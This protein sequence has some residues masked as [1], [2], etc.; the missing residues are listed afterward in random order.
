[1][2]K[3]ETKKSKSGSPGKKIKAKPVKSK[4][5][6]V[7]KKIVKKKAKPKKKVISDKELIVVLAYIKNRT[8]S[9]ARCYRLGFPDCERMSAYP[10]AT[11]LFQRPHV[12]KYIDNFRAKMIREVELDVQF[13]L[14]NLMRIVGFNPQ[15]LLDENKLPL[16]LKDLEP[17]DAKVF[18]SIKF[19]YITTKD[20]DGKEN[21]TAVIDS[22]KIPNQTQ[23]LDLL[24]KYLKIWSDKSDF[25]IKV[26]DRKFE[27]EFYDHDRREK[28]D[29]GSE[30]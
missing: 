7:V 15:C 27:I 20:S 6:K 10:L 13:V 18:Q 17:E 26:N 29:D 16:S 22:Y 25:N 30:G 1:M 5:K 19:D 12:K 24:G 11:K 4:A 3:K 28:K 9:K 23:A 14:K 8:W 21:L 2:K